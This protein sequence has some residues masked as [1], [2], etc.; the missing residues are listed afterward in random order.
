MGDEYISRFH[1]YEIQKDERQAALEQQNATLGLTPLE[2]DMFQREYP[3]LFNI[4]LNTALSMNIGFFEAEYIVITSADV[5]GQETTGQ[6]HIENP[7]PASF[8]E[9]SHLRRKFW[10][11]AG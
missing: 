9:L 5:A 2:Y 4:V 1:R 7:P 10:D 3:E 6:T 11:E 8:A